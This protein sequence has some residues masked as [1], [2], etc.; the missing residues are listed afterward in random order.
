[1]SPLEINNKINQRADQD[2]SMKYSVE[3]KKAAV[4]KF[5]S[6][7]NRSVKEILDEVGIASPT[8]YQWRDQF[9]N[10]PGMTKPTKP[11]N[12][13]V[14]EKLKAITEYDSIPIENRGE[15]LRK[16]GLHEEHLTEWRQQV[17]DALSS[18]KKPSQEQ[19]KLQA[20]K[21]K[22][23]QLEKEILRKDKALA[24]ASALLILKKKA[25][26]IWGLGEDE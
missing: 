18:K 7:G 19:K 24:E 16:N 26:Q 8:I 6:R 11:Q 9:A 10:I 12:R 13:S 20:G 17:E 21:K 5:L 25:D 2:I 14:K 1:M 3:F 4:Q 23:K 15:Y 22:V